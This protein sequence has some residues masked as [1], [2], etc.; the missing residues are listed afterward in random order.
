MV[1]QQEQNGKIQITLKSKFTSNY[2]KLNVII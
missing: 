2:H 1:M